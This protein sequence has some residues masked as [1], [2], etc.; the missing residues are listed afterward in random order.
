MRWRNHSRATKIGQRTWKRNEL[1]SNGVPWRSRSRKRISPSS[2]SSSSVLR[3][4]KLTR[5]AFAPER[6]S[7]IASSSLTKPWS[8]TRMASS[9]IT[10]SVVATSRAS[11]TGVPVRAS[12]WS[13]PTCRPGFYPAGTDPK[14]FL[15]HYAQ[16][17]DTVEL[18]TTGYR[19]PAE[20]QFR[21]WAEQVPDGFE[22]AAKLPGN[23]PQTVSAFDARVRALG[24]R[25]GPVRV[26]LTSA[27]DEGMIELLLGSLDPAHRLAFDLQHESWDGIEPRLAE[28]GAVRVGDLES[29]APFRYLRLRE[30]PY[31]DEQ[32]QKIAATVRGLAEPTYVYF[33][34]E[35]EPTAPRYAQRLR[36]LV[37]A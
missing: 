15:M 30:P 20:E 10:L 26:T 1:C 34:H 7:A 17:F 31:A 11:V 22:F 8:R 18:N 33:R 37:R 25:L 32:L 21:R 23:R 13:Y 5:A 28:A 2:A 4:A 12:C 36:E 29:P 3:R 27:R 9:A 19:L 6:S 24:D 35:D 16:A 14:E